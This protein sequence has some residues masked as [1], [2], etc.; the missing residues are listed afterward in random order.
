MS[1]RNIHANQAGWESKH[2]LQ[3]ILWLAD[4]PYGS[5]RSDPFQNEFADQIP[6]S[7]RTRGCQ[8]IQDG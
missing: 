3:A 4:R 2:V 1:L 5:V 6:Y 7:I 8:T